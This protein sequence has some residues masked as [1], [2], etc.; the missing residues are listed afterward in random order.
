MDTDLRGLDR[1]TPYQRIALRQCVVPRH[2]GD[3]SYS[4]ARS[5][6]PKIRVNLRSSAVG[7]LLCALCDPLRL[8]RYSVAAPMKVNRDFHIRMQALVN[9]AGQSCFF[10]G[11]LFGMSRRERNRDIDG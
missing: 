1:N 4:I 9:R 11:A 7:L 10:E 2:K 8:F 6:T 3:L 5:S